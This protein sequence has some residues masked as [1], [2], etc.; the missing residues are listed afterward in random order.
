MKKSIITGLVFFYAIF[1]LAGFANS[2]LR[3]DVDGDGV[4]GLSDAIIILQIASGTPVPV[5]LGTVICEPPPNIILGSIYWAEETRE[6]LGTVTANIPG[7]RQDQ[8]GVFWDF[9]ECYN[10][11]CNRLAA[12]RTNCRSMCSNIETETTTD[13]QALCTLAATITETNETYTE[14]GRIEWN[15]QSVL[16]VVGT[17][18]SNI[19]GCRHSETSLFWDQTTCLEDCSRLAA[20]GLNCRSSCNLIAGETTTDE[21]ALCTY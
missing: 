14:L 10:V 3:G 15:N 11:D 1:F 16:E 19:F 7:C 4:V 2:E 6:I 9:N 20:G 18:H 12:G 17:V 5:T 8:N 21:L 13:E